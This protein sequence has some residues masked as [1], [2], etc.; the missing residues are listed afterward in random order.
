MLVSTG[1]IT[2]ILTT[3]ADASGKIVD[4]GEGITAYGHCYSTTP[5]TTIS[6][7]KTE[8]NV[9]ASVG[10]FTSNL[11]SLL[12]A[13][14][15]YVKAYASRGSNTVYGDEIN[16]TTASADLPELTTTAITAITKTIAVSGGNITN[17][18]GT[19][20]TAKGVCWSLATITTLTNNKTND[21]SG[22]GTFTSEIT[23]LAS[24][25]KYFVRAYATNSGGTKLGNE[26]TF[27]TTS[28][29]PVPPMVTTA[30][31]ISVTS[32]SAVCGGEV[33]NEGSASVT[34]KGV[35][36]STSI[37]PLITNS[38]TNNG[39]GLGS[40][41]SNLTGLNPGTSYYI[42][43]YAT[44]NANLTAYGTE[45]SFTTSAV[46]PTLTTIAINSVTS[47]TAISGGNITNDGG[48]SVT[49]RG[50]CWS[51]S[52]TPSV[53]D[54]HTNDGFGTGTFTS[55]LIGLTSNTT[56]YVRAY[57]TNNMGT[58]YGDELNF[59][60]GVVVP[61][62]TTTTVTLITTSTASSGGNI[63]SDGGASVTV[64]GV[65]WS[66]S[67]NP[68]IANSYSTDGSGNGLFTSSIIGLT[69]NT[70]YYVRA[71][72]NNSAGTAYGNELSFKTSAVIPTLTTTAVT[73]ITATAASSGG[74][75]T[76]DG[77][78][79]VSAHG[80]CW[81]TLPGP[82]IS[83]GHT[84]DGSGTGSF[85]SSLS[86]LTPGTTYYIR[87]Y[88]TNS[89]GTG[90]GDNEL[91]FKTSAVVPTLT[92]AAVN[93]VT[94][95]SA[96][97]GGNITSD[98]GASVTARGTCW[99]KSQGPTISDNHT[100][101][102]TGTGSFVSNLAGLDPGTK[103]YIRAYATNSAGTAYG[104]EDNFTTSPVVPTLTTVPITSIT[105]TTAI[106]GGVITSS[107]GAQILAKG[108]C[109][110]T[111]T[112]PTISD[113]KTD[114]SIG[115]DSYVSDI[116]GLNP[117][118]KYYVRAYATNN[119]G[120]G[121]GNEQIFTSAAPPTVS[122][123]NPTSITNTTV[124]FNGKV[125]ANLANTIVTFEYEKWEYGLEGYSMSVNA[126]PS[127]VTGSTETNVSAVV[128]GLISGK[129]YHFRIKAVNTYGTTTGDHIVFTTTVKDPDGNAYTF[130]VTSGKAWMK[131]NLKTTKYAD[132]TPIPK[133]LTSVIYPDDPGYGWYN[134][135][136]VTYK[137]TYGALYNYGA[138]KNGHQLCP[139]GW[140]VAGDEWTTLINLVGGNA[141]GGKL[142]ET[143]TVH[144]A[145]PNTGAANYYEF[146]ALPGGNWNGY[147]TFEG[148][149]L[150]G[151]WWTMTT[152]LLDK[153]IFII[154][155]N[156]EVT[157]YT[158]GADSYY[159]YYGYSVR[160][161]RD[162]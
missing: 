131:E 110:S 59:K 44:N 47:T 54:N 116:T 132:G 74:N 21:G 72:A 46:I 120:T 134:N 119:A 159:K 139:A 39:S 64:R 115:T 66:T 78:A 33:T 142:K 124:T 158:Q 24:G 45:H 55:N 130:S 136:S 122:T 117:G 36:W 19:P 88:A 60:T 20:V 25:T 144:W 28:D 30:D 49:A 125:N 98:G 128:T 3:T 87:A 37:N 1:I 106:S 86:G 95:T 4:L 9:Q 82:T 111:S 42:R 80:V 5:N 23:L 138:V 148:L 26:V 143:G 7:T 8:I 81:S 11:K 61:T 162:Q 70:T 77:G 107:G 27:T 149:G 75:I 10:G 12:P 161:V 129:A 114:N 100:S 113:N 160:C 43:A 68:T 13:T 91:N 79:S 22:T 31:V 18:G 137:N 6:G 89:A 14:K 85:T 102:G 57:A 51:I 103:Y 90:Y 84:S 146:G 109:W 152:D 155:H 53:T 156:Y 73:S 58:A 32:S 145:S 65:C 35:C 157:L 127:P 34:V 56:Y 93:S 104:T 101:N 153:P 151:G 123:L 2:N 40:F 147:S 16:F 140:H 29:T 71:Y 63:T 41:V 96:I 133:K 94:G 141:W 118:I 154:M 121:Y 62:L 126:I 67:P 92:T 150:L 15:Y 108:V 105:S 17:Q 50:V 99:S 76:N 48:A 135:D 69:G 83:D 97:C 52:R 112:G 38:T